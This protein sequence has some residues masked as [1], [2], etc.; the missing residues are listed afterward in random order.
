MRYKSALCWSTRRSTSPP[1]TNIDHASVVAT[2]PMILLFLV[3]Q[4]HFIEGANPQRGG[5]E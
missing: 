5:G 4:K 2:V 3:A 1:R